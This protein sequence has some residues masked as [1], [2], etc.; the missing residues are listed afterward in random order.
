MVEIGFGESRLMT[1]IP[2]NNIALI[3]APAHDGREPS[4]S[5]RLKPWRG[6]IQRRPGI[7]VIINIHKQF[8]E[9]WS[10]Q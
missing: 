10:Q 3:V 6:M 8:N 4:R 9:K 5:F 1:T 2:G 7:T